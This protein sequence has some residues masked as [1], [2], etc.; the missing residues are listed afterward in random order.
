MITSVTQWITQGLYVHCD[1]SFTIWHMGNSLQ[2]SNNVR[3]T[4]GFKTLP[5]HVFLLDRIV[6]WELRYLWKLL[7]SL[8]DHII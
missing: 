6:L 4:D 5:P 8:V 1:V 3:V 7:L 2:P